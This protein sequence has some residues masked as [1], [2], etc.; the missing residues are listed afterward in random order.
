[1]NLTAARVLQAHLPALGFGRLS[2]DGQLGDN[3]RKAV[4]KAL[5]R[6]NPNTE[7]DWRQW[8]QGRRDLLCLQVLCAEAGLAPGTPDG[9][10][11]PQTEYAVGQLAHLQAHG[12]LPEPWRDEYITPAN[13]NTW[14]LDR[15]SDLNAYYGKP[16][17]NLVMLELPYPLRLSWHPAT[18]VTRTQCNAKVHASL[19][20]VLTKVRRHYGLDG[21]AELRLDLYGGG[22]N[23]R[24]KRGGTSMSTHAWGIAFD[25]DPDRNKLR[26]GRDRASFARPEYEPWWRCWE[27][28]G[29][30]SL[31]RSKNYDWMHVQ[32]ARP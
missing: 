7:T 5:E 10:W 12:E 26:W 19:E 14:P 4:A 32:A 17:R 29:W 3:T 30:V 27:A 15:E 2:V 22:F 11:G 13:P 9:W 16:G 21:I 24:E 23:L 28:E 20:K 8:P 1:M 31:G 25:F 18:V 6:Y